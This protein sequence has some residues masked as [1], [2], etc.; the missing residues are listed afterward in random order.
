MMEI[1]ILEDDESVNRGISF[2]LEKEGYGV[3][4]CKNIKEAKKVLEKE[5]PDIFICDINLPDGNGLDM[6][7]YVRERKNCHIICLT[8]L[9]QETD[10]VMGYNAGADDYVTKPFSLSVLLLKIKAYAD[11]KEEK[12]DGE[13]ITGDLKISM[14]DMKVWHRGTELSLT[15]N[16][17]KLLIL[18]VENAKQ[19]L[20]KQQILERLFDV[21]GNFVDDNTVAVNVNRLREKIE[22]DKSKPVY[23]KNV[24]GL[25]YVWNQEVE[26][27]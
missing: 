25:G 15:K 20:S 11:R 2:S 5:N 23:I 24:R 4:S 21:D 26:R 13:I 8:A 10:Y 3:F 19:I 7:A 22:K 17:W 6:V 12:Q 14:S 18:F 9:E 16:E 27:L 1:L